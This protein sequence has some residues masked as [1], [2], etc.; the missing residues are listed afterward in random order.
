MLV[1]LTK[2]CQFGIEPLP[3]SL[4]ELKELRKWSWSPSERQVAHMLAALRVG[5]ANGTFRVD[6]RSLRGTLQ[7]VLGAS[8]GRAYG[9]S[10]EM[11]F[12]SKL[13]H[14]TVNTFVDASGMF[15]LRYWQNVVRGVSDNPTPL[16]SDAIL[17][18]GAGISNLVGESVSHWDAMRD[19]DIE[20]VSEH[21][22]ALC[23]E[24]V[25]AVPGIVSA[26]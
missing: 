16:A 9:S 7:R 2:A 17:L 13:E 18:S 4:D 12:V 15:Q 24:F 19:A 8:L 11:C 3:P 21:L 14:V 26:A 5:I 23:T 6:K 25:D 10:G 22:A 1:A 20:M